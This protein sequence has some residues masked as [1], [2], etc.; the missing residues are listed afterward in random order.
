LAAF[1]D[2]LYLLIAYT[3]GNRHIILVTEQVICRRKFDVNK[4][5]R[6][7][8]IMLDPEQLT[9]IQWFWIVL[10]AILIIFFLCRWIDFAYQY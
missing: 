9:F 10:G 8:N 5:A 4:Q 3:L 6:K 7:R 1:C 2:R